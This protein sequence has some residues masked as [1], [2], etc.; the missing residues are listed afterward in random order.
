M[1]IKWMVIPVLAAA[2]QSCSVGETRKK[3]NDIAE[4]PV[5]KLEVQDTS[6]AVD[7]VADIQAIKN[8]ELR[9]RTHGFIDQVLVDEGQ[10]VKKGQLLFQLNDREYVIALNKAKANLASAQSAAS[11]ATVEL[12]RIK[13]LVEKK[14]ISATELSLGEARLKEAEANIKT[15]KAMIDDANQKLSY[16]R[17][18]S[19]FDGTI[20]RL[21]FKA[22][23]LVDEGA[24]LTTLSD[25]RQ[26]YAYFDVSEN[27]YLQFVRNGKG[28]FELNKETSLILSD[29]SLYPL[30]GKIQ[31]HESAFSGNTGSI[32][33]RAIFENPNHILKHGVSGKVRLRSQIKGGL[34]I[35]QKS[36]FEIQ[37][38]NYVFVVGK[39]SMVKMKSFVPKMQ[40]P[41]YYVC[42]SGLKP[43]ETIVYEGVQNIRDGAMIKPVYT[44][45]KDL[46]AKK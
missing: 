5:L 34:L 23:S 28:R 14:V 24:L 18:R 3:D 15:A 11:I 7:Y 22:G 12:G 37:D 9:S 33:F 16:A 43:G 27:E 26:M 40:L 45:M 46:L 1:K 35:P 25:T 41:G 32:A 30:K 21:P 20:D 44:S 8:I 4:I 38:K 39:D 10:K 6:L 2:L 36:V 42:Q 29:G 13:T 19:P 17:V 31:T